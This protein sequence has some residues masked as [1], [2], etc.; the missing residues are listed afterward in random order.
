MSTCSLEDFDG[1]F[2][3]ISLKF[4]RPNKELIDKQKLSV[5]VFVMALISI[6]R[7]MSMCVSQLCFFVCHVFVEMIVCRVITI[8]IRLHSQVYM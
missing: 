5:R 7:K 4:C 3:K 6:L 1:L 2:S 8:I